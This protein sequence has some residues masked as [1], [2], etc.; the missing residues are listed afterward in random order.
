MVVDVPVG[1]QTTG[2]GQTVQ[3]TVVP[4]LH[5]SDKVVD[6]HA[7]AVPRQGQRRCLAIGCLRFSSSPESADIPVATETDTLSA[8]VTVMTVFFLLF[9]PFF[10]LLQ[11]VSELSASFRA[12]DDEEFFVIEGSGQLVR[13]RLWTYT[14]RSVN[15]NLHNNNDPRVW[16]FGLFGPC[17]FLVLSMVLRPLFWPSVVCLNCAPL[18]FRLSGLAVNL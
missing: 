14:P 8:W 11:I 9:R 18:F 16:G 2:F 17:L 7:V 1:V 6:V 4:Q 15:P 5:S 12:L 13:S 3:K 10:T